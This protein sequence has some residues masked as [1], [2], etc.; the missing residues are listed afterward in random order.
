MLQ[1]NF[2]NHKTPEMIKM[3]NE[4]KAYIQDY[5]NRIVNKKLASNFSN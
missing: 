5:M 2:I 4:C 1:H 3:E